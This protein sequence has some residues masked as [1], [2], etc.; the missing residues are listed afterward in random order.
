LQTAS[1]EKGA[2]A[3][4][5]ARPAHTLR[6]GRPE[7][8][9]P[10]L[11][12]IHRQKKGEG[13]AA[14]T[15]RRDEGQGRRWTYDDLNK[16]IANTEGLLCGH[17]RWALPASRRTQSAPTSSPNLRTLSDKPSRCPTAAK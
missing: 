15:S 8:R 4:K 11:Y 2:A 17:L 14:S 7:P 12:C 1:V 5:S 6:E 13:K 9:R 10:E 16:F 3:A